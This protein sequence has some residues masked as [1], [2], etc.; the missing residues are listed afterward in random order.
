MK[1]I[2]EIKNLVKVYQKGSKENCV[3]KDLN[4]TVNEGE[5]IS[6]MGKSGGGKTTLLKIIGFLLN[7]TEGEVTFNGNEIST[8]WEDEMADIRRRE[9]GFIFQDSYMLNSLTAKQNIILPMILDKKQADEMEQKVEEYA[10]KL[11]VNHLLERMPEE[12]SGG[13]KQRMA[14]CRALM[15]NPSLILADEPTG[16]LDKESSNQVMELLTYVNKKLNKTIIMVTHDSAIAE[17]SNRT[18]HLI[19]GKITDE[20]VRME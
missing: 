6:I 16:N 2:L 14:V 3:L 8:L 7:P 10:K 4:I 11:N 15:N 12:L 18:L 1:Q 5:F 20:I 17:L 13:E 19:D 9:I